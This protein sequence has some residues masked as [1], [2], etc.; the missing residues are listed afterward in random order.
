MGSIITTAALDK[1]RVAIDFA[2]VAY[3]S[4]KISF[5][6]MSKRHKHQRC[7]MEIPYSMGN[8]Q[9]EQLTHVIRGKTQTANCVIGS[10]RDQHINYAQH[11]RQCARTQHYNICRTNCPCAVKM[12]PR[13][14]DDINNE[15]NIRVKSAE[16]LT[17]YTTKKGTGQTNIE[18]NTLKTK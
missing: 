14:R 16:A 1:K 15:N 7:S 3:F 13:M 11:N 5:Y 9:T 17:E 2:V 12:A 6:S 4:N 8:P 18:K 10:L